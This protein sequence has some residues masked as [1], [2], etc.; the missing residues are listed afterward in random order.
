MSTSKQ[1]S[2]R[3]LPTKKRPTFRL[4]RVLFTFA[5]F[6]LL[7]ALSAW[8]LVI[9]FQSTA[10]VDASLLSRLTGQQLTDLA[11]RYGVNLVIPANPIGISVNL[12]LTAAILAPVAAAIGIA[13]RSILKLRS[14]HCLSAILATLLVISLLAIVC[15]GLLVCICFYGVG[16]VSDL[17]HQE[18]Q[19][20]LASYGAPLGTSNISHTVAMFVPS[21][22]TLYELGR[23]TS[24]PAV[25]SCATPQLD[26][27]SCPAAPRQ[28]VQFVSIV[29]RICSSLPA[30]TD[31]PVFNHR[32]NTCVATAGAG[33]PTPASQVACL[34]GT[35]LELYLN[36]ISPEQ[37]A[38]WKE[39]AI[40]NGVTAGI[41]IATLLLW[42]GSQV[43]CPTCLVRRQHLLVDTVTA[44]EEGRSPTPPGHKETASPCSDGDEMDDS[45]ST[46]INP[47]VSPGAG[48]VGCVPGPSNK[49]YQPLP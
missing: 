43:M 13:K 40:F 8:A 44:T 4:S 2:R 45:C 30:V 1:R 14:M 12:I 22:V 11:Q 48:G 9:W 27:I 42:I 35:Q 5:Y 36:A 41:A 6:V 10:Q 15:C 26:A 33:R 34:C 21:A 47:P 25:V 24:T 31:Y 19:R 29:N 7:L 20:E 38:K 18:I 46:I 3:G 16:I 32:C 37:Q 28:G 49:S 39:T 17:T 23:C